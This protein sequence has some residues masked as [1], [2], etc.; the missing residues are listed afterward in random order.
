[1]PFICLHM[2]YTQTV[3]IFSWIYSLRVCVLGGF[4]A[5]GQEQQELQWL[6]QPSDWSLAQLCIGVCVCVCVCSLISSSHCDPALIWGK[7]TSRLSNMCTAWCFV[8]VCVHTPTWH[9][10]RSHQDHPNRFGGTR[11]LFKLWSFWLYA[12]VSVGSERMEIH[13]APISCFRTAWRMR[14]KLTWA[15]PINFCNFGDRHALLLFPAS[16]LYSRLPSAFPFL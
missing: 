2:I 3:K 13:Q 5:S 10:M 9:S 16:H 15:W 6:T 11:Y 1:M 4:L 14:G 12:N 7:V 8:C